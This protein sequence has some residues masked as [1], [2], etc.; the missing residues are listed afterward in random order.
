METFTASFAATAAAIAGIFL[1]ILAAGFM[2]R[3]GSISQNQISGLSDAT[4]NIFLPCLIFS[5]VIDTLDPGRLPQWWLLPLAGI[6]MTLAGTGLGAIAFLGQLPGKKDLLPVAG[7]QNAGYLVLPVGMA[8][9]PTRFDDFAL[10]VFLFILG[11]NPVLWSLGKLLVS[12]TVRGEPLWRG[13]VTPPL[14]ANV[15]A[16]AIALTTGS[17]WIPRP[18]VASIDLLGT[19]AVPVATFVLGA[20]L[21]GIRVG[22]RP[23]LGDA[24]RVLGIKLLLL[25]ALVVLLLHLGRLHEIDPLM[26]EFFVIQAAAAPAVALVLQVRTYGGNEQRVGA[27]M[28]LS[29]LACTVT[30][31]AW[32]AAWRMLVSG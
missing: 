23:H 31:P 30:L 9:F 24:A 5:K 26:A 4:V 22:L 25:P 15:V 19:A 1:V 21:G 2:V 17:A 20:V 11:C 10:Y 8:L 6:A 14:V 32:V 29:Y 27:V 12:R 18:I 7:I 3:R 16:V 28:L 13:L